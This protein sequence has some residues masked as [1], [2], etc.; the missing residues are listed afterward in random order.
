MLSGASLAEVAH[1]GGQTPARCFFGGLRQTSQQ[2]GTT[3][4]GAV[5][6][7]MVAVFVKTSKSQ[8]H[9]RKPLHQWLV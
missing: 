1:Q 2:P 7:G 3:G 9:P 6:V 8:V 4:S 5:N